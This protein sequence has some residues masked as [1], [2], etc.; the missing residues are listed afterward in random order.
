[1]PSRRH[2][3]PGRLASL[4]VG[5]AVVALAVWMTAKAPRTRSAQRATLAPTVAPETTAEPEATS[6]AAAAWAP[7]DSPAASDGGRLASDAPRA[8]RIGVVLVQFSGAEGAPPSAPPRAE[9]LARAERLADTARTD[10]HRAVT[11]GD[12]GS[13]DDVGLI[14]R[15]ILSE[16]I[17]LS[18]FQ[19]PVGSTSG[20][21]E[22]PRGFWIARRIE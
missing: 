3:D 22:T 2:Q 12:P 8:I 10:F 6:D 7:P 14:A 20:V 4:F 1:M 21:L 11:D 13:Q 9:A 17:E 5:A 18:L 15:G 19:L 16:A